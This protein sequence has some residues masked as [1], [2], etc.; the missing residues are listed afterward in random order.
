MRYARCNKTHKI[1]LKRPPSWANSFFP[2]EVRQSP[3]RG[4]RVAF[5][6]HRFVFYSHRQPCI[7]LLSQS[8]AQRC[9]LTASWRSWREWRTDSRESVGAGWLLNCM[10]RVRFSD[11]TSSEPAERESNGERRQDLVHPSIK[12]AGSRT[13]RAM[14]ESSDCSSSFRHSPIGG[15]SLFA[16]RRCTLLNY[17]WCALPVPQCP[18]ISAVPFVPRAAP[19]AS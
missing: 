19:P 1:N 18:P 17:Q 11:G 9:H 13:E 5:G 4:A 2:H 8:A 16:L 3:W 12:C 14:S 15:R 10:V 6:A 7:V